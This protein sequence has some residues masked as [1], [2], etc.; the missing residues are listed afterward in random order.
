[1]TKKQRQ[2]RKKVLVA[3]AETLLAAAGGGICG[4]ALH[5]PPGLPGYCEDLTHQEEG[6]FSVCPTM[7]DAGLACFPWSP[8]IA[9]MFRAQICDDVPAGGTKL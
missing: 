7:P 4:W 5:K 2:F 6:R 9:A 3:I 1:M 8:G